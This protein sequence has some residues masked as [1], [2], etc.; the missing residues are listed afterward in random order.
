M[1]FRR[2]CEIHA[3]YLSKMSRTQESAEEA[4]LGFLGWDSASE[5]T[6]GQ[7]V[8]IVLVSEDFGKELTTA[9][10]WLR[11][12]DIDIRCIRMRP[13]LDA[14]RKFV[15]VQQV[16]PLP[17]ALDYQVQVREKVISERRERDGNGAI[18]FRFWQG[19]LLLC[20]ER[21]T[22]HSNISPGNYHWI[23]SS[24]GIRGLHFNFVVT[25]DSG[26]AELYI[27]RGDTESNKAIF[28][29]LLISREAIEQQFGSSLLW[30]RLDAKRACRIRASI[31]E[32]GYRTPDAD[33]RGLQESMVSAMTRLENALRPQLEQLN[34]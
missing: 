10:L 5:D 28:D 24:S 19:L 14:D 4:I 20:K 26:A 34:L 21:Q 1:T 32:G 2:A 8:R 7:D 30:E 27:D 18:L 23:G 31:V 16:I 11:E 22:R 29:R 33:W 3:D 13:Y 17:E 12:R 25:R 6:F 15:D 9:V